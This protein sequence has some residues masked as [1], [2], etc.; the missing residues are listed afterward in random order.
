MRKETLYYR[1]RKG[2]L[3]QSSRV[4]SHRY[5]LADGEPDARARMPRPVQ[6]LEDDEDT[7][8]VLRGCVLCH[9][10]VTELRSLRQLPYEMGSDSPKAALT[11]ARSCSASKGF[12]R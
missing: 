6:A 7:L 3:R 12:S 8:G 10:Y 11:A 1:I 2:C 9:K 4:R 5:L